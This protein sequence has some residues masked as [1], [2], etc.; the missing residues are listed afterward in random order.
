MTQPQFLMSAGIFEGAILFVAFVGGWVTGV[1][2]TA[3][4]TWSLRD[5]GLGVLATGPMLILL[6][7]CLLS[8]SRG[9]VQVREF[10]RDTVGPFLSECH[11]YDI[12][13]LA[14]LAGVCEEAFFRGFLYL[15]IQ[16]WNPV[17]AVMITNLLFGLAHAATAV[18]ALLAAFLG[19]YLT[20]LIAADPTPNLLIPITAHSLYDL[21]AFVVVIRDYRNHTKDI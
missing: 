13:L 3:K 7:L 12:V 17:L 11:W 5:F 10:V 21:I 2:P 18:Y 8:R 14:L 4:L 1:S 16:E 6:V 20:A 9:I 19:L 15:W